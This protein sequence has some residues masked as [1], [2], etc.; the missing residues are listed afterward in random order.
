MSNKVVKS[1]HLS[2]QVRPVSRRLSVA[3]IDFTLMPYLSGTYNHNEGSDCPKIQ[4]CSSIIFRKGLQNI[5]SDD[6]LC[7]MMLP[8]ENHSDFIVVCQPCKR[9]F[10]QLDSYVTHLRTGGC[11]NHFLE[12]NPEDYDNS[13]I[14]S[15]TN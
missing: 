10:V 13:T 12:S 4:A 3:A 11:L 5:L 9:F 1:E 2:S 8:T 7:S 15:A 14:S 6:G